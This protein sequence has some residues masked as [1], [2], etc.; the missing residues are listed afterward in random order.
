MTAVVTH[1]AIGDPDPAGIKIGRSPGGGQDRLYLE[2]TFG[3]YFS[4][5]G[6]I[7]DLA[8][9]AAAMGRLIEA[10]TEIKAELEQR[11]AKAA[12]S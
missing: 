1:V 10:A 7:S 12:A 9:E 4:L 8:K 5:A 3:V 2:L 11:A 6:P